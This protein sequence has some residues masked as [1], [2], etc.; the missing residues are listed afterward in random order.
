MT[1]GGEVIL[2]P[3]GPRPTRWGLPASARE[4]L[5]GGVSAR[6]PEAHNPSDMRLD[7]SFRATRLSFT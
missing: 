6:G 4:F 3:M 7:R 1:L 2:L 5:I